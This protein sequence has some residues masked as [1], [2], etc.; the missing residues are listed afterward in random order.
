MQPYFYVNKS[1]ILQRRVSFVS[2]KLYFHLNAAAKYWVLQAF[3]ANKIWYTSGCWKLNCAKL[4]LTMS[5]KYVFVK[6]ILKIAYTYLKNK[7]EE[8]KNKR[9]YIKILPKCVKKISLI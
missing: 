2:G 1:H 3:A 7:R 6:N 5:L 8:K 9:K 4:V